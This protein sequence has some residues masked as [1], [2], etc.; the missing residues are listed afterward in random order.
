MSAAAAD[1]RDLELDPRDATHRR[2]LI[3]AS[4]GTG[5]T[6]T[7]SVLYLRLIVEHGL[8]P[9]AVVVSTFTDSAAA[10]LRERIRARL[11]WALRRCTGASAA[12]HEEADVEHWLAATITQAP[13]ADAMWRL[14]RALAA[15]DRAPIGTLHALCKRVLSEQALAAGTAFRLGELVSGDEVRNE[16]LDDLTRWLAHDL[17]DDEASGLPALRRMTPEARATLL[18]AA[19]A[20]GLTIVGGEIAPLRA[21]FD[22]PDA[23]ARLRDFAAMLPM[24]GRKRALQT[25]LHELADWLVQNDLAAAIDKEWRKKAKELASDD[26]WREQIAAARITETLANPVATFARHAAALL[27]ERDAILRAQ[28]VRRVLP[29][30]ATWRETRLAEREQ[31][32]FDDLITR[33]H[34]QATAARDEGEHLADRLHAQWPV[35]LIDEFQDTDAR[36]WGLFDAIH[37]DRHGGPRGLLL[38]IGDP[39]QAIYGFRGGDIATYLRAAATATQRLAL[40]VNQRASSDLITATNALYGR[41]HMPFAM[42]DDAIHY[43]PVQAAGRTDAEPLRRADGALSPALHLH[44]H[45]DPLG[46]C[47]AQIADY[48]APGR[49]FLGE[50]P[51]APGDIAVL[52]P[53]HT[54]IVDLRERLSRRRIPCV[55]AGRSDLYASIWANELRV[56]LHALADPTDAG[57]LRAALATRLIGD[58]YADLHRYTEDS[59]HWRAQVDRFTQWSEAWRRH[60]VLQVVDRIVEFAAP[61][62]LAR[63]DG[64]RALTD[65]RH[66]GESLQAEAQ[67]HPGRHQLLSWLAMQCDEPGAGDEAS[68]KERALRIES[69]AGRVQLLTLHASK[70]LEYPVVLLPLMQAQRGARNDYPVWTD[71]RRDARCIDLGSQHFG[72][73]RARAAREGLQE[74]TRLLYVALTRAKHACHLVLPEDDA[75]VGDEASAWAWLLRDIDLAS[76]T[77]ACPQIALVSAWPAQ[78]PPTDERRTSSSRRAR[79]TPARRRIDAAY[80]FSS[81]M[82]RAAPSWRE[83]EAA[84]DEQGTPV[85]PLVTVADAIEP[86]L[87]AL[88]DWRGTEFGNVLHAVFEHRQIGRPMHAQRKLVQEQLARSGLRVESARQPALVDALIERVQ[89]TL[90]A[91][92]GDH[93]RLGDLDAR[94]LRAEMGFQFRLDDLGLARLRSL[95]EHAGEHDLIPEGLGAATLRGFLSGKIDLVLV[96]GETVHVLDYKSN[97]LGHTVADYQGDALDRAMD[98]HAYRWQALLYAIAVRRYLARRQRG[99]TKALPMGDVIYLF[100]RAVG[101]APGAGIWRHRFAPDFMHAVDALFAGAE[102]AV[103]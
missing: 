103:A 19:M 72:V 30:L 21:L 3:E 49:W 45:D 63:I 66:L 32:T 29:M 4:A 77:A 90:D 75:A 96:H 35:T 26:F 14:Q 85:D 69:D 74:R 50:R 44:A 13:L 57:A 98:E 41:S 33:V 52:L 38:L 9:E 42:T 92:L 8:H 78:A 23:P 89:A 40:T 17:N 15:L 7:I 102:G 43:V 54:D 27:I 28:G 64:E 47:V 65:L 84:R 55:S 39:K 53:K 60:G 58:D 70:G 93:L 67:R 95:C 2:I 24:N 20:P 12:N 88:S 61:R 22:D 80:S 73:H 48:L 83:D 56:V 5:K 18:K 86:R 81:L 82:A 34:A 87:Q 71:M 37:R 16:L 91:D 59:A 76:L 79:V 31:F 94:S 46:R 36:Q 62:L 6:W 68:A 11:Q 1:W 101:L 25:R 97:H 10:E 100:V 99:Q 51:L